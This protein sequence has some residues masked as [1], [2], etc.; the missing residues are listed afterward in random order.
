MSKLTDF[1]S[2]ADAQR[3][4]SPAKLWDLF[5]GDRERLNIAH[6]CLD[7]HAGAE[8]PALIVAHA[9]G[10][11]E[12]LGFD[13]LAASS[14]RF[15]HWLDTRGVQPGDRVAVMLDPGVAFYTAVFGAIKRGAIAVPLFTLFGKDGVR[16]RVQDCAPRLLVT[17]PDKAQMLAGEGGPDVVVAD[18]AFLRELEAFPAR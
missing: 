13:A 8:H 6:E 5:D 14:A 17:N 3:E 18:A 16:L 15:A 11:D 2:Y 12:V 4:F 10:A 9:D 7:R 1:T